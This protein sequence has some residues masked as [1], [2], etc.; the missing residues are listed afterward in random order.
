MPN[1][2]SSRPHLIPQDVLIENI[3][4]YAIC[5]VSPD[6]GVL[7]WTRSAERLK[8]YG[9]DDIIGRHISVFYTPEDQAAGAPE[10]AIRLARDTGRFEEEG[11]RLRRNGERFWAHVTLDAIHEDGQFLGFTKI[12]RDT[13]EMMRVRRDLADSAAR[14]RML[15]DSMT[16]LV[17]KIRADGVIDYAS[18]SARQLGYEP[19]EL[20]GRHRFDLI[21]PDD[22]PLARDIVRR[23]LEDEPLDRMPNREYRFQRKDGGFEWM[24]GN[25]HLLRDADGNVEFV[26]SAFR[27]VSARRVLQDTLAQSEQR[28]SDLAKFSSDVVLRYSLS[29]E[30]SYVSPSAQSV[31]GLPVEALLGRNVRELAHPDD[32]EPT[33]DRIQRFFKEPAD[34]PAMFNEFRVIDRDGAPVWMESHATKLFDPEDG[35]L[36]G[37]QST[38]RVITARKAIEEAMVAA[39]DAAAAADRLKSDFVANI[40]HELRTPVTTIVGYSSLLQKQPDLPE[41]AKIYAQQIETASQMLAAIV[42]DVLDL[43]TIE[44]NQIHLLPAPVVIPELICE[45]LSMVSVLADQKGLKLDMTVTDDV[46][47]RVSVDPD[48]LRQILANLIGNAVKFT[49]AGAVHMTASYAASQSALQIAVTDTGTGMTDAQCAALFHR[50]S[51]V[52]MAAS[53][54]HGGTGLG[55]AISRGLATAMGGSIGVTSEIGVG[56]TF[57]VSVHA[58]PTM[59]PSDAVIITDEPSSLAGVRALVVDDN[60]HIRHIAR[61]IL[62]AFALQVADASNGPAALALV[63]ERPFDVVLLDYRMPGMDGLEVLDQIRSTVGPNQHVPVLAFSADIT[64]ITQDRFHRFDG[65]IA[66]PM[67]ADSLMLAVSGAVRRRDSTG[68]GVLAPDV[69]AGPAAPSGPGLD[70]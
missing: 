39:R 52:D 21:H 51:Q 49:E 23:L 50:F 31:V 69:Q 32:V 40:S 2:T 43:S 30:V 4:D 14:Y 3:S 12:T 45:T 62:E 28:F 53:R 57:T 17:L 33:W 15:A 61:S 18:P 34:A 8:G 58:P 70:P 35:R 10:R 16:D 55:L 26:V 1:R 44:E 22:R 56:S 20:V 47:P 11:W 37:I 63:A 65:A 48:R 60:P 46:P 6:G 24:E 13:T 68:D 38:I 19:E 64:A 66:K 42:N 41:A 5:M 54:R 25:P 9:A 7:Q 29:G 36:I 27:N 67:S 59:A